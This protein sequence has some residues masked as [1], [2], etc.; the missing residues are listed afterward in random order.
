MALPDRRR[1]A[2]D[3]E[4]RQAAMGR[5]AAAD[6]QTLLLI[7]DQ[8]YGDVLMFA[9]YMPWAL[10]AGDEGGDRD[11]PGNAATAGAAISR[12][13]LHVALGH[14]PAVCRVLPV[15]RPAAAAW[16]AAGDDSARRSRMSQ[17]S[18]HGGAVAGAAGGA[19]AG[20]ASPHR[21]RL[22]GAADPQQ[23][24]QP[25]DHAGDCWRRSARS[26]ASSLVSLQKGPAAAQTAALARA[27]AALNAGAAAGE[28]RGHGGGDREPRPA[29]CVDTS[30]GP[31]GRRDGATRPGSCCRMRRTGDGWI[32]RS[33]RPWYPS[34][35]IFRQSAPR[36][37]G[38]VVQRVVAN[39]RSAFG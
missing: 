27:G 26:R 38:D 33:D 28:F 32:G 12:P 30:V 34:L 21:H 31:S 18:R 5:R 8:G 6:G 15:L 9:R 37:W 36:S 13:A 29:G 14:M 35:R 1:P 39:M 23:R 17:P 20:R 3:A 19:A 16:H 2:A 11:Q 22:G 24:P 7:A 10:R 4:D 25:L